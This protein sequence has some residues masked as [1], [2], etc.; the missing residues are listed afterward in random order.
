M[1]QINNTPDATEEEKQEATN[2]VNVGLAQAIQ[3][4]NNAHST[5]EVN[6]SKTHSIAT[7]KSILPN[8]IKNR[9]L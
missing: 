2:R 7:I 3:N 1:I 6:E 9:L 4:I 5:Q 8:V